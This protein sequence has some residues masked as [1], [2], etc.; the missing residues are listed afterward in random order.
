MQDILI[1][2]ISLTVPAVECQGLNDWVCNFLLV[3]IGGT[4][5]PGSVIFVFFMFGC[6]DFS[7]QQILGVSGGGAWAE[8]C[9]SSGLF[10]HLIVE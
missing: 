3:P 10:D 7:G 1:V 9:Q 8:V 6:C 5:V 4:Q 2:K